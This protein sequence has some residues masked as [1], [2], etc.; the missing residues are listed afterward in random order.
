VLPTLSPGLR[1][2]WLP[3]GSSSVL[4]TLRRP[5]GS[6]QLGALRPGLL[7]TLSTPQ[8]LGL[9]ATSS[10]ATLLLNPPHR[11]RTSLRRAAVRRTSQPRTILR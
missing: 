6:A 9:P 7:P 4:P 5:C 10:L 2:T 1:R 8:S 11:P 3:T